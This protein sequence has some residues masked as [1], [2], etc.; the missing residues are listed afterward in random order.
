VVRSGDGGEQEDAKDAPH[1]W[2]M[3]PGGVSFQRYG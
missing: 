2:I 1:T 3:P